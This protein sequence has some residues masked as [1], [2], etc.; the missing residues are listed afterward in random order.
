M[1]ARTFR[2]SSLKAR[3]AS[4][5]RFG[6]AFDIVIVGECIRRDRRRISRRP[7]NGIRFR[8]K[9]REHLVADPH[10]AFVPHR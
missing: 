8:P 6:N 7:G 3:R 1:A 9:M 4:L 2:T 5:L 10:L